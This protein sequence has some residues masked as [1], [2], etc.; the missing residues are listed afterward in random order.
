MRGSSIRRP[1]DGERTETPEDRAVRL[2][3]ADAFNRAPPTRAPGPGS[4]AA[5]LRDAYLGVLKL[6]VCDLAAT[7]TVSVEREPDGSVASHVLD[8]SWI[9]VR[10]TGMDWPSQALTMTGLHRLNDLQACVETVVSDGVPGHLIEAG[11]WRGGS[12]I[13][14]RATLDTLGARDRSVYVADSFQGF[15]DGDIDDLT[16]VDYL[17]VTLDE[18]KAN[19]ARFGL[20]EGVEWVP[21]F[22]EHSL[23]PLAPQTWAIARLDG[24]SYEATDV[25]LRSLYRGLS[26]GGYLIVD[27]YGAVRGCR[28]AVD[29]FRDRHGIEEPIEDVD[30]TC[31]RWRKE[32]DVE[33]GPLPQPA[34]PVA[35]RPVERPGRRLHV[36]SRQELELQREVTALRERLD[37]AEAELDGRAARLARRLRRLTTRSS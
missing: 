14:M 23:P 35:A 10:S 25:S 27:D 29:E 12:S 24:D 37:A 17:A 4:D 6:A 3:M 22:F 26:V 34:D 31:A 1:M 11:C 30:F 33:L 2:A 9:R 19:F 18:V 16:P 20:E 21:G 28:R 8:A 13:V 7:T 36:P 15:P 5:E 32:R